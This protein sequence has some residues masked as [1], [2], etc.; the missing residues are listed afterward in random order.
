MSSLL[1]NASCNNTPFGAICNAIADRDFAGSGPLGTSLQNLLQG[2]FVF[3]LVIVAGRL[4]RQV[5]VRALTRATADAQLRVLVNNGFMVTTLAVAVFSG[6]TAGGLDIKV[7]LTFGGLASLTLGLAFQDLLRNVL[8]GVFLLIERP[9]RIGDLITSGDVTGSV[10]TIQLRTTALRTP[11]GK[12]AILP[13]TTAFNNTIVNSTAY[14][15]RRFSVAVRLAPGVDLGDA[16]GRVRGVLEATEGVSR[17]PRPFIEP[18]L[19][20]D[21]GVTLQCRYWVQ[22]R[23][24]EP[25]ALAATVVTALYDALGPWPALPPAPPDPGVAA[26]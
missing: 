16:L 12:L 26:G 21:G 22:Y 25:D 2:L 11:D 10:Q 5:S 7:L 9:F 8:A 23:D 1:A 15:V 24:H 6:L 13:N 20:S 14:D 4:L 17:E 3:A 19:D 18:R